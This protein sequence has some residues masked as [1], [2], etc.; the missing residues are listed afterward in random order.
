MINVT[1]IGF[2]I[3]R[4]KNMLSPKNVLI[5]G[6]NRGIG[7]E[8]VKQFLKLA[9]P[10]QHLFACCRNPDAATVRINLYA[11]YGFSLADFIIVFSFKLTD[12]AEKHYISTESH[13]LT[14]TTCL[15]TGA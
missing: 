9:N 15:G 5:T 11:W 13:M 12:N 4:T 3:Q 1:S 2:G 7:L 10:P 8:F 6:C 14:R